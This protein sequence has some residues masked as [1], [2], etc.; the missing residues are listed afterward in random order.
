MPCGSMLHL[1]Y[2]SIF[3]RPSNATSRPF[4]IPVNFVFSVASGKN[5]KSTSKKKRSTQTADRISERTFRFEQR[6]LIPFLLIRIL[7]FMVEK[8]SFEY[9]LLICC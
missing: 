6:I 8:N 7:V 2:I 3:E 1:A 5:A 4:E 9:S